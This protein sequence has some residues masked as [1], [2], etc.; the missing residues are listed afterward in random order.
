METRLFA[1]SIG[2]AI[3]GIL[4]TLLVLAVINGGTLSF[5]SSSQANFF[6]QRDTALELRIQNIERNLNLRAE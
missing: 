2:G 5:A 3:L 6:M 1:A 4:L